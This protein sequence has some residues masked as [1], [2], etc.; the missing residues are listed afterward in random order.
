MKDLD[1]FPGVR[2]V[3]SDDDYD[4]YFGD[5]A[6]DERPPIVVV[7]LSREDDKPL[8]N[9]QRL[10]GDIDP[11]VRIYVLT[12]RTS[13]LFT[14]SV[15]RECSVFWGYMLSARQNDDGVDTPADDL[16]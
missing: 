10:R 9:L 15:G 14:D 6:R 12:T 11:D 7:T 2:L 3:A 8:V 13:R 16:A 5:I 4:L 1:G